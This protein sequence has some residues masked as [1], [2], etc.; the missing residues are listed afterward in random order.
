MHAED[1]LGALYLCC[2]GEMARVVVGAVQGSPSVY[3]TGAVVVGWLEYEQASLWGLLVETARAIIGIVLG[4]YGW[5]WCG[6][7]V[8]Y[9]LR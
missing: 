9:S 6:L 5:G 3:H 2:L 8:W 1:F 7:E 4:A